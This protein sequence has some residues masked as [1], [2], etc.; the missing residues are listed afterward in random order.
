[1][2]C[3]PILLAGASSLFL[4]ALQRAFA[5]TGCLAKSVRVVRQTGRM[6]HMGHMG[7]MGRTGRRD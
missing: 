4:V 5:P 3:L 1:M 6:G 7:H 2:S